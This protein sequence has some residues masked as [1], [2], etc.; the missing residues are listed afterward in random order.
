M[1]NILFRKTNGST[2]VICLLTP[3]RTSVSCECVCVCVSEC[4]CIRKRERQE[5]ERREREGEIYCFSSFPPGSLSP[6]LYTT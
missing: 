4:V 1:T 6:M 2:G 5:K 3:K